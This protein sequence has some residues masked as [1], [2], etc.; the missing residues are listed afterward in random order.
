MLSVSLGW[1]ALPHLSGRES[2]RLEGALSFLDG[3]IDQS[4]EFAADLYAPSIRLRPASG[5]WALSGAMI[6]RD[7]VAGRPRYRT[8]HGTFLALLESL[9]DDYRDP[10]CWRL[11]SLSV[12]GQALNRS[13]LAPSFDTNKLAAGPEAQAFEA[14]ADD[15]AAL[16]TPGATATVAATVPVPARVDDAAPRRETL[17]C[18]QPAA[19]HDPDLSRNRQLILEQGICLETREFVENGLTWRMQVLD[20]GRPGIA[21][22]VLHDDEDA[23]FDSALYAVVRY[24]GKVV[25]VEQLH[26]TS[27]GMLV[28]PNH[29]FA[30]T[31]GQRET[32][33]DWSDDAAP[34]FTSTIMAELGGPPYFAL[35]NNHDG[36]KHN[37]GLGNISVDHNKR[38]EFGLPAHAPSGRLAD[39]DN[40]I[41]VSGRTPP[42]RLTGS[43]KRLTEELRVAGVNVIYEHVE[44]DWNDCS[45]SNHL[46]LYGGAE[47]GQYFNI[48]S[49]MG[50]L[51][52]QIALIDVLLDILAEESRIAQSGS[53]LVVAD[54]TDEDR[55]LQP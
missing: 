4:R 5:H 48:E 45:L 14:S 52:S 2:V 36:H 11:V 7:S 28:D 53:D 3:A 55:P 23:A 51:E 16:P 31:D 12:N 26:A 25:D 15:L 8:G 35:H 49:E 38:N 20:S 40:F 29:N 32:C 42:N 33:G 46:L 10:A 21:W 37:G 43:V 9:C 39:E 13:P 44:E 30:H 34:L 19:W 6:T 22:A 41:L 27:A 18:V 47:P 50:D 1:A 24:G 17:P 54:K